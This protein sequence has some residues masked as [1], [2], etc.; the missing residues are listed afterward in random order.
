MSKGNGIATTAPQS[1]RVRK[2]RGPDG[3]DQAFPAG[4][5]AVRVG[6]VRDVSP[7]LAERL[8]APERGGEWEIV[9]GTP[10]AS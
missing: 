10:Q 4:L 5:R 3:E 6:D 2:V 8:T 9:H 7:E 1:V